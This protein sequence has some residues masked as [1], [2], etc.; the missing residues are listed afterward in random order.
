MQGDLP[1]IVS[2]DGERVTVELH[3]GS[4]RFGIARIPADGEYVIRAS[5]ADLLIASAP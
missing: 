2:S 4:H 1:T 5:G 3:R